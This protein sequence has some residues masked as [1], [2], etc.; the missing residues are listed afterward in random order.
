VVEN[1]ESNWLSDLRKK[2]RAPRAR[3]FFVRMRLQNEETTSEWLDRPRRLC[4]MP[5]LALQE[6]PLG[7]LPAPHFDGRIAQL[8]EQLTLNQRVQ[9]SSPCAPTIEIKRNQEM[10]AEQASRP[11]PLESANH[12]Q[13]ATAD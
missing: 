9:G 2:R 12:Y 7:Q 11:A 4:Y 5:A 6:P 10:R 8:V 3:R 13:V 1:I